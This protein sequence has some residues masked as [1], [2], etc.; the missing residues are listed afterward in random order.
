M[1]ISIT[2]ATLTT[3]YNVHRNMFINGDTTNRR[4]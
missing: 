2:T 3:T 4:L 1:Y